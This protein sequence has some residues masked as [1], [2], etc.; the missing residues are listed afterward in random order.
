MSNPV[1]STTIKT[2]SLTDLKSFSHLFT[3]LRDAD[4]PVDLTKHVIYDQDTFAAF[5]N[6]GEV[7]KAALLIGSDKGSRLRREIKIWQKL[8]HTNVARMLGTT[9]H[10]S[11]I[12]MVSFWMT[13]GD[14]HTAVAGNLGLPHRLQLASA[15]QNAPHVSSLID[16]LDLRY[17]RRLILLSV[18]IQSH[19]RSN[20]TRYLSVHSQNIIHGDLTGKNV[21]VND[22]GV[23]CIIDFGLSVIQVEFDGTHYLTSNVGG[24]MRYRAPELMPGLET[25]ELSSFKPKLTTACDIWSLG[26]VVLEI[27]SGEIPYFNIPDICLMLNILR[28]NIPDRPE[29]PALDD[30][31][32]GYIKEMWGNSSCE[33]P[34]VEE[35]T[36]AL[37]C[38]RES[39]LG[40]QS[41]NLPS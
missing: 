38:L 32:W 39:A 15:T 19:P 40:K 27:L 10:K 7:H 20:L 25:S 26:C 37:A 18:P 28:G 13:L 12:G 2:D 34:E 22:Q 14:L 16:Y 35:A 41:S 8:K 23:A 29:N 4:S 36:K 21:L 30:E 3:V 1:L 31:F 17:C 6:F 5:G 11:W 33:R 9:H 24:A